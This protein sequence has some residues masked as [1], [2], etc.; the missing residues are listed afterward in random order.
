[1]PEPFR[2]DY[3]KWSAVFVNFP[4]T[5]ETVLV[6]HSCGAGFLLRY[7]GEHKQKISKLILVAPW[8]DPIKQ[9]KGFLDFEIDSSLSERVGELHILFSIDEPTEGVKESV[10]IIQSKFPH[11]VLHTFSDKGHFTFEEMKT[12]EFPQLRDLII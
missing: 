3:K 12:L 4:L 8:L 11:A 10:E 6:G 7:L 2:P 5:N 9:R 1:M